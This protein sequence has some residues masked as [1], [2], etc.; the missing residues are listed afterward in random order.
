[1]AVA[2]DAD[3]WRFWPWLVTLSGWVVVPGALVTVIVVRAGLNNTTAR[4]AIGGVFDVLT[5]FPRRV[6]PFA[7]PCYGERAVAPTPVA[8][9]M[10]DHRR[11]RHVAPPP[12]PRHR[13]VPQPGDRG[14]HRRPPPGRRQ[15]DPGVAGHLRITDRGAVPASLPVL[16][17]GDRRTGDGRVGARP[18]RPGTAMA[19]RHRRA[20][21]PS[22]HPCAATRS[23]PPPRSGCS[24]RC[25]GAM[26]GPATHRPRLWVT[27]ATTAIPV[28]E[29][30]VAHQIMLAAGRPTTRTRRGRLRWCL[31]GGRRSTGVSRAGG[32]GGGGSPGT[33][34]PGS[35]AARGRRTS[36]RWP[37][38]GRRCPARSGRSRATG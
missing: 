34:R 6:H 15:P 16:L 1:M 11:H 18:R 31:A 22:A 14:H 29:A 2:Q 23:A 26:F 37:E 27:P 25:S 35:P 24:T 38:P 33:A 4:R 10:A 13:P 20:P 8:A 32:R 12:N 5:F 7:P 36:C 19:P 28:V 21:M 30:W 17:R 3:G 9:G